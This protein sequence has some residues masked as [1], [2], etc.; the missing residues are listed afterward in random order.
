MQLE[1][2]EDKELIRLLIEEENQFDMDILEKREREK[3]ENL[4][5]KSK[6]KGK[7]RKN[8]G[9]KDK[10]K[11]TEQKNGTSG[12]NDSKEDK[13]EMIEEMEK[14]RLREKA[15]DKIIAGIIS[16]SNETFVAQIG[17]GNW[18]FEYWL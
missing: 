5:S 15:L 2:E 11:E 4:D 8:K 1:S 12:E 10:N 18:K 14:R 16:A 9:K 7:K 6:S 17:Y 3:M 13:P